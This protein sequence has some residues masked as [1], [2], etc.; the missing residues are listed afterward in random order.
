MNGVTPRGRAG[1]RGNNG[2]ANCGSADNR[3]R[4]A[5]QKSRNPIG[6]WRI[7]IQIEL[8]F[9][10]LATT[11]STARFT[12]SDPEPLL[13]VNI[14]SPAKLALIAPAYVPS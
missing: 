12:I 7:R 3:R 11:V 14:V 6:E 1:I 8:C 10:V 9:T 4:V 5:I 2:I 13:A